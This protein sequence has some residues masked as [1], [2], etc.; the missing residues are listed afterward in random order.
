MKIVAIIPAK[1]NSIR[2]PDKN[3]LDING[4]P[5]V[6]WSIN[7]CKE[8]KYEIEVWV[9]SEDER[10]LEVARQF[11]AKTH[12]RD[13]ELSKPNVFKQEV[14][15][16]VATYVNDHTDIPVDVFISL[17][18]NSPQIRGEH[19]DAGLDML[20]NSFKGDNLY[21]VFSVDNKFFQNAIYRM[22]RSHY[23]MQKDL[24]THCGVVVCDIMDINTLEDYEKVKQIM[25]NNHWE[26]ALYKNKGE[27]LEKNYLFNE[28]KIKNTEIMFDY[29]G[30]QIIRDNIVLDNNSKVLELGCNLARNLAE[31][32]S[33]YC[34]HV[35]GYDINKESIEKNK[36][37]FKKND[38]FYAEDLRNISVLRKYEDNHFDLGITMGFLMHIPQSQ[39]KERL[40]S[41]L[42]RICKAV[43]IFE[44]F[45]PSRKDVVA[46]NEW[47]VS[48]EDYRKYNKYIILTDV[49]SKNDN[50]FVLFYYQNGGLK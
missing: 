31:A 14:I 26:R 21:E 35:T 5:M 20:L 7:A 19:I 10:V 9:S 11:V 49:V 2:L 4:K 42:L 44:I 34:C 15:R 46:E 17:Q 24:S 30:R 45:D 12:K 38:N 3:I 22:F 39:S 48:F 23:V 18:A 16:N 36:E 43:C 6:A 28:V 8:S 41:E 13:V 37:R 40:I 50:H 47:S 29:I 33:R 1:G 27:T 32:Q 25:S